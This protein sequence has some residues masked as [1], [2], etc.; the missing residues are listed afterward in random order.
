ML[1]TDSWVESFRARR[2]AGGTSSRVDAQRAI[3]HSSDDGVNGAA[4][5]AN[6]TT[7]WETITT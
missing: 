6:I 5:T 2:N 1:H 3:L 4:A 7:S